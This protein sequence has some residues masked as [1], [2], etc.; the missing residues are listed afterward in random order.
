MSYQIKNEFYTVTVA[1]LG[2]ELISVKD[3]NGVEYVWQNEEKK[4]WKGHA[5]LLFPV[6]GTIK[7]GFYYFDGKEYPTRQHG[8]ARNMI[9]DLESIT[10]TKLVMSIGTCEETLEQYPFDFK[11]TAT[12][13]LNGE[14]LT[15]TVDI[16]NK[17]DK[18]MPFMFGW[19]PAFNLPCDAG[20]DIES[21]TAKFEGNKETVT[22]KALFDMDE[23][24]GGC[25]YDYALENGAY[26]VKE[27]EMYKQD[28]IVFFNAGKSAY[29]SAEGYPFS[30]DMSW[31]ENLKT[32]CFW[33]DEYNEA[34]YLCVEPWTGLLDHSGTRSSLDFSERETVKLAPGKTESF[35]F[36]MIF[37]K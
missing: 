30:I 25:F 15:L 10:D 27:E 12:Y 16:D 22:W 7:T 20:Q 9:F 19:H 29:L 1:K 31:S 23:I 4:F 32:L 24:K 33:K 11:L 2:A 8:F 36:N 17:S 35:F 34:K 13:E 21:Y 14:K 26:R 28:T 5:P 3:K 37:K 6:C 18:V